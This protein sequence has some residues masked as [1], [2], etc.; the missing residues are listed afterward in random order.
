LIASSS[1]IEDGFA[2]WMLGKGG[3]KCLPDFGKWVPLN[4]MKCFVSNAKWIFVEQK[5]WYLEA[6]DINWDMFLPLIHKWNACQVELLVAFLL[7]LDESTMSG[8]HPTNSKSGGLP[9]ISFEPRKP[10]PVG[11]MLQDTAECITGI[12][13]YI[14]QVL[15]P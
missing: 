9:N 11:T 12:L 6:H 8:W 2:C 15:F 4:E 14:D 10:V 5:L 7:I 13:K 3:R 1:E